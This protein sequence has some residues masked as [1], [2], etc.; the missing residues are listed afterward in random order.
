MKK[1]ICLASLLLAVGCE[2]PT[3]TPPPEA[4]LDVVLRQSL[5]GWG[6][7]P[8]RAVPPQST[9]LVDLGRSLF[10]DRILSGNRD[11][12]CGTCHDPLASLGDG[13]SLS[14]GTGGA[15]Q[16]SERTLGAGRQFVPR[17]APSLL[18]E[19]LGF[20]SVLWDGRVNE[21]SGRGFFKAP[22]GV[23][24]PPGLAN[25]VAAQ[26]MLPI[27][28]RTE[29]RGE[30]GDIDVFG[31]PNE[32]ATISDSSVA[33]IWKA[34]MRRLLAIEQ[35]ATK[36]SAAYPSTPATALGFQH[37]ANAIAAFQLHAFTKTNSP[38]D[39]YLARDDRALSEDAK[40]GAILFFGEA[41]CASCHNGA[42][43]G[44][45]QF[46]N[47]G[48]PQLGPGVGSA[49]PLDIGRAEHLPP[50]QRQF[51]RFA[52]RVPALRNV[53]LTAPYM[54]NGVYPNLETVVRHYTNVDSAQR[55]YD[56]NQVA[57]ALRSLH[58]GDA[59][60]INAV[61]QTLD[62]RLRFRIT[63]TE[64]QRKQLVEFLKSLTDPAARNLEGIAPA[65]VPSGLS[66][67]D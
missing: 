10:F 4:S 67:R 41:R 44:G 46:A 14:V 37:A 59:A 18:N 13:L 9:A 64:T 27:L 28:S 48:V 20:F 51:Y 63:L 12:S 61:L 22:P 26:A 30:K 53:E 1:L 40:R 15:G 42:L 58:R 43:L 50:E 16:H 34:T 33:E 55:S 32:L 47:G 7:V 25:L 21:E 52:F 23:V 3:D 6:V 54:H 65:S 19:G 11:I 8:I 17:N 56:V 24:F 5:Q 29:M 31:N 45:M 60:T 57:P 39:R 2:A 49:V 35:Y 36:F 38:F 66:I 62:G